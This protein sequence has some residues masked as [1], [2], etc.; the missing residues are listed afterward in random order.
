[1]RVLGQD[2]R[3]ST[4]GR[5]LLSSRGWWLAGGWLAGFILSPLLAS[6]LDSIRFDP[7]LY[8]WATYTRACVRA[9]N[10]KR[11][12]RTYSFYFPLALY[13]PY[14]VLFL[15]FIAPVSSHSWFSRSLSHSHPFTLDLKRRPIGLCPKFFRSR[16]F[17]RPSLMKSYEQRHEMESVF[18]GQRRESALPKKNRFRLIYSIYIFTRRSL[19]FFIWIQILP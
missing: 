5:P 8:A 19:H 10:E 14:D 16:L 1:V 17:F 18:E 3:L 15:L 4:V 6:R 2:S 7:R 12:S 11:D 13:L 9:C